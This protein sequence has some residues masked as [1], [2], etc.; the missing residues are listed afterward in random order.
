MVDGVTWPTTLPPG[1]TVEWD[2]T[3]AQEE[4]EEYWARPCL[5][6][7]HSTLSTIRCNLNYGLVSV[8]LEN[9]DLCNNSSTLIRGFLFYCI[10]SMT[11]HRV[12]LWYLILDEWLYQTRSEGLTGYSDLSVL[13]PLRR[14][15]CT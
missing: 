14:D 10:S 15:L 7:Y 8:Y 2:A 5:I 13:R 4:K 3:P 11:H 1:W 6:P 9:S 12:S